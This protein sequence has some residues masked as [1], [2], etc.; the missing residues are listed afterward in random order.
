MCHPPQTRRLD[1]VRSFLAAGWGLGAFAGG[2][3]Q[4]FDEA[5]LC[6][7]L[8]WIAGSSIGAVTAAI[9]AGTPEPQ[10]V[11]ALRRFWDMAASDPT[12]FASIW[13]GRP[14][15][16][17]W[18]Q[19]YNLASVWQTA[20]LG[21]PGLFRPRLSFAL[22]AGVDDVP[23][24]Y[25][26]APLGVRLA[27]TVD[28]DRLNRGK[29]R[30][31]IVATDIPT[32]ERVI[33]DTARGCILTPAHIL[34]SCALLPVFAPIE[35]EGRLLGDGGLSS[36]TPLD[37]ITSEPAAQDMR[38]FAIDLFAPQ[39][40]RPHTLAASASRS[41]DLVFGN[42]TQRLREGHER[43]SRL[44][45]I[46][47]KLGSVVPAALRADPAIAAMLAEGSAHGTDIVYLGYRAGVDEAGPGKM[48]DFSSETIADRWE[49]GRHAMLSALS[50]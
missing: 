14:T 13:L 29:P 19:A 7:T 22:R 23:A 27:E 9:I 12:P 48:F 43:E 17:W 42:Q 6:G 33:F 28:F 30:V 21:R 40:S 37:V 16:G 2:A 31:S 36:N 4:G 25:D 39:G 24:L 41:M 46:I 1:L 45:A 15:D 34:A 47:D 32:G 18:R 44:R 35:V 20:W 8:S 38:C 11:E 3:Y 10:R 5:G 26:L 50:Q 49:A